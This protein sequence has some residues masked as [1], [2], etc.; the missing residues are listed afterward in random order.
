MKF[1]PKRSILGYQIERLKQMIE[2]G[3]LQSRE[4]NMK[5]L[6]NNELHRIAKY[7]VCDKK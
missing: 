1:L 4:K 2:V 7:R 6:L 3:A 5:M